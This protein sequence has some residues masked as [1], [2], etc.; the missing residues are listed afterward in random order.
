MGVVP[1]GTTG[2][3]DVERAARVFAAHELAPL[4]RVFDG[5]NEWAGDEVVRWNNYDPTFGTHTAASA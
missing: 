2:F 1:E 5:L 4:Q 3:G